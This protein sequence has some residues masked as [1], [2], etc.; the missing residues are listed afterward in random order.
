MKKALALTLCFGFLLLAVPSLNFAEKKAKNVAVTMLL[1]QPLQLLTTLFPSLNPLIGVA[2]A[3][4]PSIG[5]A[6][7]TGDSSIGKPGIID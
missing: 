1:N 2:K 7:P 6:R 4:G 3:K 5:I